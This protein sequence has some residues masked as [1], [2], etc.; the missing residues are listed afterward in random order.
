MSPSA[1][2]MF[3]SYYN[4]SSTA[5]SSIYCS[6]PGV[7]GYG[8]WLSVSPFHA[9]LVSVNTMK[10][11][12]AVYGALSS[13]TDL[14]KGWKLLFTE[15]TQ[16]KYR[17]SLE[18]LGSTKSQTAGAYV[19]E[20]VVL[21]NVIV[22]E[23]SFKFK[24][25]RTHDGIVLHRVTDSNTPLLILKLSSITTSMDTGP[26]GLDESDA[27]MDYKYGRMDI[28]YGCY[29]SEFERCVLNPQSSIWQY[30]EHQF[31]YDDFGY[32]NG[33]YVASTSAYNYGTWTT[34]GT[35][36]AN[37]SSA[38]VSGMIMTIPASTPAYYP[39]T[40]NS[41]WSISTATGAVY[42]YSWKHE[43]GGY[44]IYVNHGGSTQIFYI[45]STTGVGA[46]T[47]ICQIATGGK[48]GDSL[49]WS[50][51]SGTLSPGTVYTIQLFTTLGSATQ[52]KNFS[53]AASFAK[54]R[55]M[56]GTSPNPAANLFSTA[57]T[58]SWGSSINT[59]LG[60]HAIG[61][62]GSGYAAA[63]GQIRGIYMSSMYDTN[64]DAT[65]FLRLP[66]QDPDGIVYGSFANANVPIVSPNGN[67]VKMI[68]MYGKLN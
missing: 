43:S 30:G 13:A 40:L 9:V 55:I 63:G 34:Y 21:D 66:S 11:G 19:K 5:G 56:Y 27:L 68:D 18:I 14:S 10:S 54:C 3:S 42:N 44:A 61:F 2:G 12:F 36:N 62:S 41:D 51:G 6:T 32:L 33:A 67:V 23:S 47:H 60:Q 65:N 25:V 16:T 53:T 45:N 37:S 59:Q 48:S 52:S 4:L 39:M 20:S 50:T 15:I 35:P 1:S 17:V 38:T 26:G 24:I 29:V 58:A 22:T 8:A 7:T 28:P 46:G 31:F 49:T 64:T 57:P